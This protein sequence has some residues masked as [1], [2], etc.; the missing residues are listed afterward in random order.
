[1]YCPKCDNQI[2]TGAAF[3][4]K[5]GEKL[6]LSCP[7]CGNKLKEEAKFCNSCGES[8]SPKTTTEIKPND[9]N[10]KSLSKIKM[11]AII[12]FVAFGVHVVSVIFYIL[13]FDSVAPNILDV[14]E[15]SRWGN[16]A[17]FIYPTYLIFP[18]FILIINLLI[19]KMKTLKSKKP[20]IIINLILA[21]MFVLISLIF[22]FDP[23]L[24]CFG[25]VGLSATVI[26]LLGCIMS[27][28][29]VFSYSDEEDYEE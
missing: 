1:M 23:N 6:P 7:K 24:C 16:F 18:I 3:C 2:L 21:I 8:L 9:K 26:F 12:N 19:L 10:K 22:A 28:I 11:G 20:L 17:Y 15:D 27:A 14:L 13:L 4:A 5:C 29:G 25:V